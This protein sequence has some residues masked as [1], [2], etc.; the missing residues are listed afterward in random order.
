MK[1]ADVINE[2]VTYKTAQYRRGQLSK[3]ALEKVGYWCN[4]FSLDYGHLDLSEARRGDVSRW[5]L[6]HPE[7]KSPH[8]LAD[9][10]SMILSC[11][12]WAVE[13]GLIETCPYN[14]PRDLPI[15]EP[16]PPI[17]A[18]EVRQVLRTARTRGQKACRIRFRLALWFMWETG[19]RT[20]EVYALDWSHYDPERGCFIMPSK[21]FRR[22]GK[23]RIIVL[24][25][26][27]W[28]L[29]RFLQRWEGK[30]T[31]PVFPGGKGRRWERSTFANMFRANA[32]Q[33]GI[34]REVTAY[35]L[36]HGFCCEC[37]EAGLGERQIADYMGHAN[38]RY[39]AWYGRGVRSKVEYLRDVAE[40]RRRA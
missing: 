35:S 8:T 37:L 40:D 4:K 22:T 25:K 38:T 28:R 3:R 36:R 9:A 15:P 11:F 24:G 14:R 1:I 33:A 6:N 13:D 29:I 2:F 19:I 20:S 16:R 31:G 30:D 18:Q 23:K 21:D 39:I 34:R 7:L 32:D 5:L 26:R 27:A 10:V 17:T 12:R